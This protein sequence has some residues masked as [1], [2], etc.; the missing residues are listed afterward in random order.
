MSLNV[1]V[2]HT[3]GV[4]ESIQDYGFWSDLGFLVKLMLPF[5]YV[6]T[7]IQR[8]SAMLADVFRYFIYLGFTIN[9]ILPLAGSRFPREFGVHLCTA[10]D[11]RYLDIVTPLCMLALF[12]HPEFR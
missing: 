10:Y 11:K 12:L 3:T 9:N 4:I 2:F 7:A 5:T 6:I 8:R 1:N